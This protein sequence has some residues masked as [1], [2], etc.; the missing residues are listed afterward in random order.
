MKTMCLVVL[1]FGSGCCSCKIKDDVNQI[2]EEVVTIRMI[3]W[4]VLQK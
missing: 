2:R 4:K 3:L 1:L